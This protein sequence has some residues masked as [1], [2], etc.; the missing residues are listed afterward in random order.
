MVVAE[1]LTGIAL[2]QQSVK[3]IKENIST[4]QDIGQI[5][6]QIDNLFDGERQ[7][8]R[9]KI[10]ASND[11]FSIKSVATETIN[12]RLAQEEMDNMRQLID[13]RFGFGT[14]QGIIAERAR[15]IQEQKEAIRQERLAKQK[16][17][18]EI[19][20]TI[21][22]V[23]GVGAGAFVLLGVLYFVFRGSN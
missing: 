19:M 6:G 18:E 10:K 13:H 23:L 5:A 2:V 12:Y 15:R 21:L 1:I 11:P 16:R 17:Q 3:F 9:D 22:V 20:E 7:I 4:V 8:Q 14:W